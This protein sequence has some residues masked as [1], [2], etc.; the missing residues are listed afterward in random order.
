MNTT[1]FLQRAAFI[2]AILAAL[3]TARSASAQ[4]SATSYST[5]GFI[6]GGAGV[7]SVGH[8]YTRPA[9]NFGDFP[10]YYSMTQAGDPPYYNSSASSSAWVNLS[11]QPRGFDGEF[12]SGSLGATA[13][14]VISSPIPN[15][16]SDAIAGVSIFFHL[17]GP[18]NILVNYFGGDYCSFSGPAGGFDGFWGGGWGGGGDAQ[19][20]Q[21]YTYFTGTMRLAGDYSITFGNCAA[22]LR[23]G[24]NPATGP[25]QYT[26][27]SSLSYFDAWIMPTPGSAVILAAGALMA[28]SR[29]R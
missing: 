24:Q 23:A 20:T 26:A 28:G 22:S 5:N 10:L 7:E 18:S 12:F 29:R 15:M 16:S 27:A 4:S 6:T 1:N 14:L 21:K 8:G 13:S 11:F 3:G 17:D 25:G 9:S 19:S 2:P